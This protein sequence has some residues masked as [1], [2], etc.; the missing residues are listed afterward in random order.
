[1]T[2]SRSKKAMASGERSTIR[3]K[4][5]IAVGVVLTV[6]PF[7]YSDG[8]SELGKGTPV[9]FDEAMTDSDR[10]GL[11]YAEVALCDGQLVTAGMIGYVMVVTGVGD[12]IDTARAQAY[13]RVGKVV[14]PNVRYRND[15]GGRFTQDCAMLR[16]LG[17]LE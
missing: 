15:I 7:P 13:D 5:G 4:D 16:K 12:T 6:P 1:M 2:K 11:H 9:C 3:T 17:W 8:Y 10:K 14:I